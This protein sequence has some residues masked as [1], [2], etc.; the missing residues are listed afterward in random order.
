MVSNSA[1]LLSLRNISKSYP[2]VKALDDVSF[3]IEAGKVTGLIGE[4]G[5]GKST[6]VKLLGGVHRADSGE[7]QFV[8]HAVAFDSTADARNA[9]INV[10][11]QEF[12]L[13]PYLK[14]CDNL[15]LGQAKNKWGWI[16]SRAEREH[17]LELF[18]ML[19]VD[20]DLNLPV[21]KLSVAHQQAIEIAKGLT[22]NAKLLVLDEPTAALSRGE[23][24]KLFEIV[25]DLKNKGLGV[26]YIS[27]RL[28]EIAHLA[29]E[30]IV[31]RDGQKVAQT[32]AAT[33]DRQ[34]MIE[35][36]VGRTLESEFPPRQSQIG[37]N[38]L[39][40]RQVTDGKK[41]EPIDIEIRKGEV[42]GITGL[43][44]SGRTELARLIFGADQK[45]NGQIELDGK[46]LKIKNP[47]D[48]IE[49]GICL[50][51]ED[52]KSEGLVIG[53]SLLENFGLPNLRE[54][55]SLAW[56]NGNK[57]K[58][59]FSEKAELLRLKHRSFEQPAASLSGGNQQKLVLAKWLQRHC[60]VFILDEPTR[61]VD[62]GAR[63]EVYQLINQLAEQGKAI[64]LISSELPEVLGMSDRII[65]MRGGKIAGEISRVNDAT[66]EQIMELAT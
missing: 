7:M 45:T 46:S 47:L 52:R 66:Q 9:G 43:V 57:E 59:A 55:S 14:A 5:A 56:L 50:L 39:V 35:A 4:N 24:E 36:M 2:G 32:N 41:L 3:D 61:G 11:Y 18:R 27:H 6:L 42:L 38:R 21:A 49:S 20:I 23:T 34:S 37:S 8:G 44:G 30:I 10:I 13:V 48:A 64:I 15:F 58:N 26:I 17:A 60:D 51:T 31:L 25:N 40:V 54:F 12:N 53:H 33:M 28:E 29:D 1:A 22:T 19:G 62:V 63:F 16:D 65:V